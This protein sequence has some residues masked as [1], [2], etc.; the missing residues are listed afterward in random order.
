MSR[1]SYSDYILEHVQKQASWARE[2]RAVCRLSGHLRLGD[3]AP[4]DTNGDV[5]ARSTT[6]LSVIA[7]TISIVKVSQ[8][9]GVN[10]PCSELASWRLGFSACRCQCEG[11]VRTFHNL[12]L[13]GTSDGHVLC[14]FTDH[15]IGYG[16]RYSAA[17]RISGVEGMK[18]LQ[19]GLTTRCLEPMRAAISAQHFLFNV[20]AVVFL[21]REFKQVESNRAWWMG[22]VVTNVDWG[23]MRCHK[24]C[25]STSARSWRCV[26]FGCDLLM[27]HIILL[28]LF[29][30]CLI[31]WIDRPCSSG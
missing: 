7:R 27:G 20:L 1:T 18:R 26:I 8:C 21:T 24:C 16:A 3:R 2:S 9:T 15:H 6:S 19:H 30:T 28:L 29:P 31:S 22:Q 25:A 12:V 13:V 11:F 14:Q 4:A 5:R 17:A 23:C 10:C